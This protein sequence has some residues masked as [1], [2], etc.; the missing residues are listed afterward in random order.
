MSITNVSKPNP[1]ISNSAKVSIGETWAS[2]DTTWSTETRTW[3]TVSK[4][5]TNTVKEFNLIWKNTVFP[6]LFTTPW[7]SNDDSVITNISKPV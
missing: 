5:I 3:L 1:S 4:L 7:I 2:I 6:W